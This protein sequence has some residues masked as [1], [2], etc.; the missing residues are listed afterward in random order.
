MPIAAAQNL[1]LPVITGL[2]LE[3]LEIRLKAGF[4]PELPVPFYCHRDDDFTRELID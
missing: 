1:N 4:N 2:V 3:E